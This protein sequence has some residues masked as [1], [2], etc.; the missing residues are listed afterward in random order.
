MIAVVDGRTF[1]YKFLN[2]I[3]QDL[4]V[5]PSIDPPRPRIHPLLDTSL[6]RVQQRPQTWDIRPT[7]ASMQGY[8]RHFAGKRAALTVGRSRV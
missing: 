3:S 8:D 1:R 7:D 4:I 2:F 5:F 6:M